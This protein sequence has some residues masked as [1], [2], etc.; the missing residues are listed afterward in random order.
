MPCTRERWYRPSRNGRRGRS[1]RKDAG[2]ESGNRD[3]PGLPGHPDVRLHAAFCWPRRRGS[4]GT[5]PT[6]AA[7]ASC[8]RLD[9]PRVRMVRGNPG[10][11]VSLGRRHSPR[12]HSSRKTRRASLGSKGSPLRRHPPGGSSHSR[13]PLVRFS[14]VLFPRERGPLPRWGSPS[15]ALVM[16]SSRSEARALAH[17]TC[18]S[19]PLRNSRRPTCPHRAGP[20]C[21]SVTGESPLPPRALADTTRPASGSVRFS[22]GC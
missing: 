5:L 12:R 10:Y 1:G 11:V 2:G 4:C 8:D 15:S 22:T 7:F 20:R 16:R 6:L 18:L 9:C 3:G 17:P 21:S 13:P 19:G 14:S